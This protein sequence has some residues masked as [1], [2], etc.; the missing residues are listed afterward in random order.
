MNWN[1]NGKNIKTIKHRSTTKCL[2]Y[3]NWTITSIYDNQ[4]VRMILVQHITACL[5]FR[6]VFNPFAS[7]LTPRNKQ[8]HET[9]PGIHLALRTW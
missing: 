2:S 9:N 3:L 1:I 5:L 4:T 8:K 6:H 7:C